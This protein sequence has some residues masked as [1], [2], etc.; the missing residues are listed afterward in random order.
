MPGVNP[1]LNAQFERLEA[2]RGSLAARLD[3]RDGA[4]LNR[5]R[6]DGGWSVLQMVHH[7]ITAEAG[8]LRYTSKKMLGGTSLPWAGLTSRMRLLA[9]KGA[10]V[11]PVRFRAPAITADVPDEVDSAETLALWQETREGWRKL[12]A[13][14]PEELLDRM[15]F[16]HTLV[17][18]M[19]LRDTLA[20]LQTHLDHHV[21]QIDRQLGQ[22]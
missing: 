11:S 14:F 20:F 12:L 21:R 13:G 8:T 4:L 10:M 2:T 18:L 22:S 1:D 15:V 17:G 3:G 19:G 5:P 9:L 6:A 16:R 7:V